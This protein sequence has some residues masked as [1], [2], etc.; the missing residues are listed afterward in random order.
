MSKASSETPTLNDQL[1]SDEREQMHVAITRS[2][3]DVVPEEGEDTEGELFPTERKHTITRTYGKQRG[4]KRGRG[5]PR[6]YV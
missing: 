2:L 3:E 1:P 4:S 6:K 5:R